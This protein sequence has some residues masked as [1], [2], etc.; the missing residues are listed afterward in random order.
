M[1]MREIGGR[2]KVA[3]GVPKEV[4]GCMKREAARLT[5]AQYALT[6]LR[7]EFSV[8]VRHRAEFTKK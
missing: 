7:G 2:D 4:W 8:L 5:L 6:F 1:A 3:P